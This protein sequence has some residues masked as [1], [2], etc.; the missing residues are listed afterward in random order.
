MEAEVK[1]KA[2]HLMTKNP[3]QKCETCFVDMTIMEAED[4]GMVCGGTLEIL[5]ERI[6]E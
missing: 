5:L 6:T 2:R 3:E 4:A 1:T